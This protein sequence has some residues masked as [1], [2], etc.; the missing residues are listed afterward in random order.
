MI[1]RNLLKTFVLGLC[2][3]ALFAGRI[4]LS[5][6]YAQSGGGTPPTHR[7][8]TNTEDNALFEIQAR[9]DQYLFVDHVEEIE[10]MGF[11]VI[12]TGVADTYVEVGI[13]PYN[14]EYAAYIYDEFGNELVKVVDTEEV[15][16]YDVPENE[17]APD[18]ITVA[19]DKMGTPIMDMGDTSSSDGDSDDKALIK[20]REQLLAE[21]EDKLDIQIESIGESAEPSEDLDPELIWQTGIATD[22]PQG[23]TAEETTEDGTDIG[24]VS[25]EDDMVT[26]SSTAADVEN[27]NKGLP[28]VSVIV[29]VAAGILIISGTAYTSVKKKTAKKNK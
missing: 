10:A 4:N 14:E 5:T 22:L 13:T 18:A 12:Y 19:P 3:S 17:N 27:A 26:I 15:I 23:D 20:E 16:L 28:T 2:M 7:A 8:T 11:K 9:M 29:I 24:P 1:R 25:A 6:A 21:T